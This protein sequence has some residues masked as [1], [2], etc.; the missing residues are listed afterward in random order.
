MRIFFLM[1]YSVAP[2]PQAQTVHGPLT[3]AQRQMCPIESD[4]ILNEPPLISA[5]GGHPSASA[6]E[7]SSSTPLV[8]GQRKQQVVQT[9]DNIVRRKKMLRLVNYSA[10]HTRVNDANPHKIGKPD[11]SLRFPKELSNKARTAVDDRKQRESQS[12]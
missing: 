2:S 5:A 6:G 10:S 3:V 11:L 12:S 9:C 1:W 7:T 4:Y 8:K